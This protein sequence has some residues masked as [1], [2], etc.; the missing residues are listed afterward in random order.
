MSPVHGADKY[1]PAAT[2]PAV[3]GGPNPLLRVTLDYL[4][5]G[6]RFEQITPERLPKSRKRKVTFHFADGT[7]EVRAFE[8]DHATFMKWWKDTSA[9]LRRMADAF[10]EPSGS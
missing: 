4:S 6:K 7:E 9:Y 8:G 10:G 3:N 5:Q 2:P 1:R